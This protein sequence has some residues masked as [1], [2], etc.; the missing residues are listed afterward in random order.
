MGWYEDCCGW[1]GVCCAL[2][3]D[4]DTNNDYTPKGETYVAGASAVASLIPA[5]YLMTP[6]PKE[7]KAESAPQRVELERV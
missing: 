7:A 4:A 1:C 3:C 2:C 5:L 6:T